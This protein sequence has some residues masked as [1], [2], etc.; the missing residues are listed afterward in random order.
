MPLN[1]TYETLSD[2]F[3]FPPLFLQQFLCPFTAVQEDGLCVH[4]STFIA[5]YSISCITLEVERNKQ[6]SSRHMEVFN[7]LN[8][9][10]NPICICWHY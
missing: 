10:L 6:E 2:Q 8:A 9:E 3:D 5:K 1:S 7:P 4:L